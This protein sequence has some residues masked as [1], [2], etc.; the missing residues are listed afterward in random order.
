VDEV[1]NIDEARDWF[2][3]HSLGEVKCIKGNEEEVCE[4]Y[5]DAKEFY[6]EIKENE[7]I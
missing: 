6:K 1:N 2:L 3:S 5:L 7:N 4:T